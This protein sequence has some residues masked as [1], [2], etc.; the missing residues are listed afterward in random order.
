MRI[1]AMATNWAPCSAVQP[2]AVIS[3]TRPALA[4][5]SR[6]TIA[7]VAF[8]S[9]FSRLGWR[10]VTALDASMCGSVPGAAL[11]L[12]RLRRGGLDVELG[13]APV[14]R[15]REGPVGVAGEQHEAGDQDAADDEG[16]EEDGRREG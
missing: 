10:I 8:D 9:A 3:S 12:L 7:L 16:V 4:M 15:A 11:A 1:A 14:E 13:D 6:T 2:P 5:S